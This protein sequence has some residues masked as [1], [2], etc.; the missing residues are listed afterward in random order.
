MILNEVRINFWIQ[1]ELVLE[2]MWW[3]ESF[4]CVFHGYT[5]IRHALE[6]FCFFLKLSK[7]YE[8]GRAW[9]W[10]TSQPTMLWFCYRT[11]F[12]ILSSCTNFAQHTPS[13]LWTLWRNAWV[14]CQQHNQYPLKMTQLGLRQC[15]IWLRWVTLVVSTLFSLLPPPFWPQLL[16]RVTCIWSRI[17]YLLTSNLLARELNN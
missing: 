2:L 3:I 17:S 14:Y 12:P 8:A 16:L 4:Q 9:D 11:H 15:Y 6:R 7:G 5:P 10:T 1:H 13:V